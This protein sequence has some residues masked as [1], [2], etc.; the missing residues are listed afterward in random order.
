METALSDAVRLKDSDT[1]PN[2]SGKWLGHL[3]AAGKF[4]NLLDNDVASKRL[5]IRQFQKSGRNLQASRK[6]VKQIFN[7]TGL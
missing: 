4:Q 3:A 6:N 7:T 5:I 2:F 1:R